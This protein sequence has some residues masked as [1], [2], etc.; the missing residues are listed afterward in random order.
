MR[1]AAT[2][3]G[4]LALLLVERL[5]AQS[6]RSLTDSESGILLAQGATTIVANGDEEENPN[7]VQALQEKIILLRSS[8]KAL[9]ESLAIANN[10]AETFKRQ[11]ADLALKLEA[12]GLS[13]DKAD[14]KLEQR[15]L[16]AVRDL[17]LAKQQQD[18]TVNQLIRLTEGVQ[19]LLKSAENIDPQVRMTVETELR[20]TNEL[21]GSSPAAKVAAVDPTLT[22]AMVVDVK[23]DLS[24]VV[25][26]V[27]EK[28]EVRVGMPFQ[29][30]R[31]DKQ[32]G[33]VRVID[34]RERISGAVI[35]SLVSEKTPIKAGDRL[36]VDARQ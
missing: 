24:L 7:D 27:G 19:V 3:A 35:Q 17:R 2:A 10:E 5:G 21:L 8:I 22:D 15:L 29:V 26:N 30:W 28:Q 32:V 6:D 25:A 20:K 11:S 18:D 16:S 9:T 34:V 36:K 31:G 23:E 4:L 33:L 13:S 14:G 1:L 12:I